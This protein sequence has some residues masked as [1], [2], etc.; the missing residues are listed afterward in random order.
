LSAGHA[1]DQRRVYVTGFSNGA[2]M[3]FRAGAA[4]SDRLAAIA[5][6]AGACWTEPLRLSR[7]VSLCYVTGDADTL[8]PL[9]GGFPKLAFGGREQ[10]G[11][12]KAPVKTTIEKWA[13]ALRC[14]ALPVQDTSIRGVHTLRY[15]PGTD[16]AE[17]V[18]ITLE[19]LG[20][21]WPGG[22]SL[23]PEAV[24]GKPSD[25]LNATAAIWDFFKTHPMA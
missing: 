16:G 20:H 9:D 10:G 8:N 4:L 15:G 17:V 13:Q 18:F 3:A 5:P 25:K 19:G 6:V 11:R 22:E 21:V 2:S 1:V 24:V 14:P 23:L 7:G 12:A